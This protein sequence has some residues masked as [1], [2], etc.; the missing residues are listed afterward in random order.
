[1][2]EK[3]LEFL[4][5]H[6]RISHEDFGVLMSFL[7]TRQ[8]KKK[9]KLTDIGEVEHNM[10]FVLNGLVRVYF[11]RG[12]DEVVINLVKEGGITGSAQSF[13][14][15]DPSRYV[16]EAAEPLTVLLISK[17]NLESLL[18]SGKRWERIARMI[19][20][21][22]FLIQEQR[23]LDNTRYSTRERFMKFIEDN[24]DLL[25]RVPQKQLA[26]YLNIKPETFSRLKHLIGKK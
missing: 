25:L 12:K 11:Y 8:F 10:Y 22:Y 15:G 4:N 18:Q 16:V 24:P 23:I 26:S 7:E 19:T 9:E 17:E 2:T 6:S 20:T 14:T 21:Q 1:M 13:F 3:L 5:L